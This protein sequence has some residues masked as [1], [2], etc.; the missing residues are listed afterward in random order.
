MKRLIDSSVVRQWALCAALLLELAAPGWAQEKGTQ[1]FL[2]LE[3]APQ[4][5]LPDADAW[6]KQ[7]IRLNPEQLARAKQLAAPARPSIWE[8]TFVTFIGRKAGSIVGYAIVCEEIGKHRPIT[9][10]VSAGPDGR[11]RDTAIM[12]YREPIGGEVRQSRFLKQ[13][14]EKSLQDPIMQHK[15]IRNISGATLSVQALSRGVRKALAV[16]KVAYGI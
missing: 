2:A 16:M 1:I 12:A 9:F 10:I 7:E 6:E 5:V 15:D 13:F 8:P 14:S 4:V 3:K 11:V